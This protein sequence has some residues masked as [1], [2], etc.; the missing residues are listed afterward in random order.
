MDIIGK[1]EK[2]RF[3]ALLQ[4]ETKTTLHIAERV[5]GRIQ[6]YSFDDEASA[7]KRKRTISMG[8][9]CFPTHGTD[10]SELSSQALHLLE[11]ARVEGG[12]RVYIH[13]LV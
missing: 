10:A 5:L 6:N 1:I 13:G 3:S 11:K 4:A 2:K 8:A 12:N 9:A 7:E